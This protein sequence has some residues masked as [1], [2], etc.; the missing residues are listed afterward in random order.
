M[1]N[2]IEINVRDFFKKFY[3]AIN[4]YL[5]ISIKKIYC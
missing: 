3:V 5:S 2:I 4:I 1:Y